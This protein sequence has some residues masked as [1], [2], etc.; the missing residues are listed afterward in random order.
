MAEGSKLTPAGKVVVGLFVAA[1]LF[2]AYYFFI[3]GRGGGNA[4]QDTGTA[5]RASGPAPAPAYASPKVEVG[6]AYG[7]EKENWL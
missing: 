2:G 3:H 4:A 7:T 1:C 5:P 6:I